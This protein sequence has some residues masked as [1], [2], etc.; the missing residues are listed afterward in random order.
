MKPLTVVDANDVNAVYSALEKALL[1]GGA[2]VFPRGPLRKSIPPVA[3]PAEVPDQVALVVETS[4][5]TGNPKR[6]WLAAEALLWS[7]KTSVAMAGELG[8]WWLALPA[9]YIAG[10]QV[11]TRSVVSHTTPIV[12]RP[13]DDVV[14]ALKEA[15]PSLR[16]AGAD[17]GLYTS[18]VPRQLAKLLDAADTDDEVGEL[19]GLF[20]RILLGGQAAPTSLVQRAADRGHIVTKTYGAAETAGG[21]VWDGVPWPGVEIAILDDRVNL[22]GPMLAGGYLGDELRTAEYFPA[23]ESVRWYRSDDLGTYEEGRLRISGRADDVIVS[24]GVKVSLGEIERAVRESSGHA[25]VFVVS[26]ADKQWGEV[27]LLVS[28]RGLPLQRLRESVA[29]VLGDAAKPARV[30]VVNHIPYLPSGKV[31]RQALSELVQGQPD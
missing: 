7:A 6:V 14:V 23:R 9:H 15:G 27:P 13:G 19:L 18:L 2:A 20:S 31:D 11:L 22:S 5:S 17:G 21:C 16:Q 26:A 1:H 8:T 3:L 10:L 30:V 12:A 28:T 4:G 25:E 29:K 24:G